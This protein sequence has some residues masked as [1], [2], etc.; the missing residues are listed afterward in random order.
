MAADNQEKQS[1][2]SSLAL[3]REAFLAEV[4]EYA[5]ANGERSADDFMRHFSA[6][7]IMQALS[8]RP[9]ERAKILTG[10]T[11]TH[12]KI[13]PRM[14]ADAAGE[15]LQI[16][17]DETLTTAA[18]VVELFA[19]DDK[20]RYL[21]DRELWKFIVSGE[22]TNSSRKGE[23]LERSKKFV[24]YVL[25]RA[26]HHKLLDQRELVSS[27]TVARL[28]TLLPPSVLAAIIE[29]SLEAPAKF[30]H[31]DVVNVAPPEKLVAHVPVDYIW[32]KVVVPHIAERHKFTSNGT[33]GTPVSVGST[34]PASSA[35]PT[36]SAASAE[37][38]TSSE[39]AEFDAALN[40]ATE[41]VAAQEFGPDEDVIVDDDD[42]DDEEVHTVTDDDDVFDDL[43]DEGSDS[44][45]PSGPGVKRTTA[46]SSP[47][48]D[49]IVN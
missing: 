38:A 13:A 25:D 21:N 49:A 30:T 12:A 11:G 34:P 28:T 8:D 48:K 17:L 1:F 45:A 23:A 33:D 40:A 29:A 43:L 39:D 6:A 47:K 15:T 19:A 37:A 42:D 2:V 35:V 14:S 5:L 31:A 9:E 26:L 3:G 4:C 36:A 44:D 46:D 24:R 18:Q 27:L 7:Q 32:Q 20:Q 22:P 10:A 16:A 41:V